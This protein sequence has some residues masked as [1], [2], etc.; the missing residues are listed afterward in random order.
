MSWLDTPITYGDLL[1]I[2][3]FC[4]LLVG[5][6]VVSGLVLGMLDERRRRRR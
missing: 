1:A 2:A 4:G 5:M 3:G 6:A